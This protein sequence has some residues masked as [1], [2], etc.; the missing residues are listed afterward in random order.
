MKPSHGM[1]HVP[2]GYG[3]VAGRARTLVGGVR[4]GNVDAVD[5]VHVR[6]GWHRVCRCDGVWCRQANALGAAIAPARAQLML[7]VGKRRR[8][9]ERQ[10]AGQHANEVSGQSPCNLNSS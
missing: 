9:C 5:L 10:M 8:V 1:A 7:S 6:D 4:P 2:R 3:S